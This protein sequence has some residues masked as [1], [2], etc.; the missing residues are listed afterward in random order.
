M[1]ILGDLSMIS[2]L[3]LEEIECNFFLVA[4]RRNY[5]SPYLKKITSHMTNTCLEGSIWQAR[6]G[7]GWRDIKTKEQRAKK[8]AVLRAWV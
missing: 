3:S 7:I 5:A 1:A 4:H 8:R 2:W 6:E